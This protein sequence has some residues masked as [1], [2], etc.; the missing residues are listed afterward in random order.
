[1]VAQKLLLGC[2]SIFQVVIGVVQRVPPLNRILMSPVVVSVDVARQLPPQH[3]FLEDLVAVAQQLRSFEYSSMFPIVVARQLPP[4]GRLPT[5]VVVLQLLPCPWG[6][7]ATSVV[8]LILLRLPVCSNWIDYLLFWSF[9]SL[10][11][12]H[13]FSSSFSLLLPPLFPPYL[14]S[15]S[16]KKRC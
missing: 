11:S 4:L 2:F 7:S 16:K 1:M 15:S 10:S 3:R 12:S 8:L 9:W 13:R 6:C 14:F 5:V